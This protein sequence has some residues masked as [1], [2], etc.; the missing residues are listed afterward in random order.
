MPCE[1]VSPI[2]LYYNKKVFDKVGVKPPQSWGEIMALVPKFNAHDI[3]PFSLG[4]QSRWTNMM[5]LEYLFDRIG[6]AEVFQAIRDGQRGAWSHPAALDA[7]AKMQDLIR[8][9]GFVKGF[10]S[11]TADSGADHALLSTGKAA[12]MLHGGWVYQS[13][14]T[15]GGDFVASGALGYQTFPGVEGG[16][17]ALGDI[18]GNPG[19]YLSISAQASARQKE[20]A[21]KFFATQVLSDAEVKQ[22]VDSGSVPI[23]QGCDSILATSKDAE[24]LRFVYTLAG[25]APVLVQSWDQTLSPMAAET[26]LENIAKLFQLSISPKQFASNLNAVIGK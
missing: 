10:S 16:T 1:C 9:N 23:V 14:A 15:Q 24:W 22:W 25:K 26:L 8:A 4:G 6:G 5:W 11:I 20:I 13:M 21:K 7:L 12:M 17:G 2:V 19:Q 3:A 18:V